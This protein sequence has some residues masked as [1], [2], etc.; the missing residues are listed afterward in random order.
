MS[1]SRSASANYRRRSADVDT[2]GSWALSYG[3]MVTLLLMF[4]IIFFSV[5]P[6]K[7]R[8]Q[9][10]QLALLNE[11]NLD[12]TKIGAPI[13]ALRAGP[14]DGEGVDQVLLNKWGGKA[15]AFGSKILI[16]FPEISFFGLGHIDLSK[17]GRKQLQEFAAKFEP[18]AGNYLVAVRAFTDNTPVSGAGRYSDNLELSALRSIAGLRELQTRG[19]PLKRMRAEGYGELRLSDEMQK[20][21]DKQAAERGEVGVSRARKIVLII[22]PDLEDRL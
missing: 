1:Y 6:V 10:L 14:G 11:L 13:S 15:S 3:D 21:L 22:E 12:K 5:D 8:Y 4:F 17:D 19:I 2:E 16:E 7:E 20:H 9:N 18:Y